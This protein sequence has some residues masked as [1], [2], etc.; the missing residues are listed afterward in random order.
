MY[1]ITFYCPDRRVLDIPPLTVFWGRSKA[2]IFTYFPKIVSISFHP[3][4]GP[5]DVDR[6]INLSQP[7]AYFPHPLS[8]FLPYPLRRNYLRGCDV[9][10]LREGSADW[11]R[12]ASMSDC[13]TLVWFKSNSHR[14]RH[15]VY[16]VV[17][18]TKP[19]SP[20]SDYRARPSSL[21]LYIYYISRVIITKPIAAGVTRRFDLKPV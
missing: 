2:N 13:F 6:T 1:R 9:F 11:S 4:V 18:S 20:T 21:L 7:R 10:V 3:V 12:S 5:A 16:I 17:T 15:G 14:R 8:A 19:R